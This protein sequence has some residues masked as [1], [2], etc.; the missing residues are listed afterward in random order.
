MYN[1]S[2]HVESSIHLVTKLTDLGKLTAA[3][4]HLN[5]KRSVFSTV[6]HCIAFVV[7][8]KTE[9]L[10]GTVRVYCMVVHLLEIPNYTPIQPV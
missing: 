3:V 8:A 5:V 9:N 10:Y 6:D 2:E 7:K 4:D 1:C